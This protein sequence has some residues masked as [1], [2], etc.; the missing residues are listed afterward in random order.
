MENRC[1]C[2]GEIIP[3]G[4]MVCP[5]CEFGT[6][7]NDGLKE[8]RKCGDSWTYCDGECDRCTATNVVYYNRTDL[9]EEL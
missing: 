4:R 5:M 7:Q 9:E 2:C 3:E 6:M 8:F 1:V